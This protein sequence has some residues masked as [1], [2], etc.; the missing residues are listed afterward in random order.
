M[1]ESAAVAAFF[2]ELRLAGFVEGQNLSVA[3]TGF[4]TRN[5]QIAE[6]AAEVV[7][8][9]PDVIVSGPLPHTRAL[10]LL[11]QSIPLVGMTEDMVAENLVTSLA[12]P[13]GNTTGIS[14]LSP[15]LDS[16]RQEILVEAVP[17]VRR[18]AALVDA[19]IT[20]LRH[21][22][23]LEDAAKARGVAL[24]AFGVA[25]GDDIVPAMER[26]KASGAEALNVL[27]TPLFFAHQNTII[28]HAAAL[29]LPAIYQ[30][31]HM[32]EQGGLLAYGP[33]FEQ[34]YRQRARM[35]IKLLRGAKPA[36]LPVEQPTV[37]ELV[38][39]LQTAKGIGLQIPEALIQRADKVIE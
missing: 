15:E 14:L 5:E 38:I 9:A 2:D 29:R 10:Q 23:A 21:V 16:K 20:L 22:Q 33:R 6:R 3:Q 18:V 32:A 31:P 28:E 24:T 7:R 37:F 39:N 30:W 1:R 36:E 26:A 4:G 17:R 13:G 12:R 27:A 19:G 25:T 35:V 8:V 34:V 11:T